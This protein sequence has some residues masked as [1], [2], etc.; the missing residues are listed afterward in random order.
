MSAPAPPLQRVL[1]QARLELRLLVRSG[2]SLVVTFGIPLGILLFF[3]TVDV[4]PV[5]AEDPL[6]LLL[7]GTLAIAVM[8][9]GFVA[10]AISTAFERKYGVLKRLGATPLTRPEFLLAKGLAVAVV[11]AVQVVVLVGVATALRGGFPTATAGQ[12]GVEPRA[13]LWL[14]PLGVV[15]GAVVFTA[16]GLALAGGVRAELVLAGS[17]GVY[18]L[19]LLV[20][21]L[22]FSLPDALAPL[23][24]AT[25]S[26]ALGIVLRRALDPALW[27]EP[28][29]AGRV[30]VALV[31]LFAWGLLALL[32]ARRTFRWEP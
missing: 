19:L 9:T 23:V 17:N 4:L 7:P 14:V 16:L 1:A 10:Q 11:V 5:D 31:V 18:L 25:P 12:L 3:G 6:D 29:L 20:S 2:E 13:A 24:L 21:D 8:S 32:V 22:V 27:G 15:L 26:G 30:G 28:A